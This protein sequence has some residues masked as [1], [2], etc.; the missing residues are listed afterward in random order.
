MKNVANAALALLVLCSIGFGAWEKTRADKA[1]SRAEKAEGTLEA[2]KKA[3]AVL[4]IHL[5]EAEADRAKWAQVA[6]E[7]E[8]KEGADESLSPYL[9][10]VLD[11]LQ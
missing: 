8:T 6:S 4:N 2:Y 9:R 5:R 1:V 11:R 7:L 10:A 3:N